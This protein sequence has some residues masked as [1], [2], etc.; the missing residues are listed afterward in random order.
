MRDSDYY[1][2]FG[3]DQTQIIG[4]QSFTWYVLGVSKNVH[5]VNQA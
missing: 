3:G 5:K 1:I 2:S 4:M